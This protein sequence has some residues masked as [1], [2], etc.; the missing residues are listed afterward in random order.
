MS[1]E[2]SEMQPRPVV[3]HNLPHQDIPS[4]HLDMSSIHGI[5]Q[6]TEEASSSICDGTPQGL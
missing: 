4:I 2:S 1:R 6:V 3:N 5:P